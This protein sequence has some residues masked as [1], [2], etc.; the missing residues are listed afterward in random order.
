MQAGVFFSSKIWSFQKF[1]VPLRRFFALNCNRAPENFNFWGERSCSE[2]LLLKR[3]FG[4]YTRSL[5]ATE[6]ANIV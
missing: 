4:T 3:S 5:P 1:V 2:Y 6:E